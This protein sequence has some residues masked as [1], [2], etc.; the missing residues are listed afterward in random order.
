MG[1][2]GRRCRREVEWR[3]VQTWGGAA[4]GADVRLCGRR[5]RREIVASQ[6]EVLGEVVVSTVQG[7]VLCTSHTAAD[8]NVVIVYRWGT[9][10]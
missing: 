3:E 2:S 7:C 9:H 1:L 8:S 6:A 4:G 5:W 10:H